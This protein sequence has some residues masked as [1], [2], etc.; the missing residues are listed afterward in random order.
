MPVLAPGSDTSSARMGIMFCLCQLRTVGKIVQTFCIFSAFGCLLVWLSATFSSLPERA[1]L[2]SPPVLVEWSVSPFNSVRFCLMYLK[3][4]S[5]AC[6]AAG[7]P[8]A[9]P[10]CRSQMSSL[11]GWVRLRYWTVR[12]LFV[13]SSVFSYPVLLNCWSGFQASPGTC[14]LALWLS[15]CCVAV[16]ALGLT[17]HPPPG[18][19]LACLALRPRHFTEMEAARTHAVPSI[20]PDLTFSR[21]GSVP[22]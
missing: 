18:P 17:V 5:C 11:P 13:P 9:L 7:L 20:P 1:A 12:F 22:D 3:C 10:S 14:S 6:V 4:P 15:L 21:V 19:V 16:A 8:D 2:K